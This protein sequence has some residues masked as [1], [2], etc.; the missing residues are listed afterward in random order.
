MRKSGINSKTPEELLVG[1]GTIFK[2]FKYVYSKVE[3]T[4]E[5]VAPEGALEIVA[6]GTEET[7]KTIQLKKILNKVS[8][9]GVASDYEPKVGD[10]VTGAWD[11]SEENVLGATSGGN[12]LTIASELEPIEVDG[13]TV[14]V[15]GM[16]QNIGEYASLV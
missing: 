3:A 8:F 16:T 4:E 7:E 10:F 6:D 14:T 2:N 13:A 9:I 5:G 12:K 11:D 1:A 15:K